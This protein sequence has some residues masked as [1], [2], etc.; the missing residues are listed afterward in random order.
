[1]RRLK[2]KKDT[3]EGTKGWKERER[4]RMMAQKK[5]NSCALSHTTS[6]SRQ[7]SRDTAPLSYKPELETRCRGIFE[8][9][10]L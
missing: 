2:E 5:Y 6:K 10:A 1:M 4:K 8:R 3:R 7:T 9:A